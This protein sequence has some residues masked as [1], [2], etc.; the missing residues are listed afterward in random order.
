MNVYYLNNIVRL[1][2]TSKQAGNL[3]DAATVTVTI[4]RPDNVVDG[5]YTMT[6][7]SLGTYQYDYTPPASLLGA[8]TNGQAFTA[9]VTAI[10]PNSSDRDT[11]VVVY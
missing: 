4:T 3:V 1:S 11:F 10:S 2:Y 5:P 7:L 9:R 8:Q 6:R